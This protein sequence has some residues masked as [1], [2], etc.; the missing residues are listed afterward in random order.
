MFSK[1]LEIDSVDYSELHQ[2]CR[3]GLRTQVNELKKNIEA[4]KNSVKNPEPIKSDDV[5]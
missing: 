4:L 1:K 5:E 2:Q 3:T